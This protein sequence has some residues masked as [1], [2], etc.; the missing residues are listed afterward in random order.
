M[1][2]KQQVDI[3]IIIA[4]KGKEDKLCELRYCIFAAV[5][6]VVSKPCYPQGVTLLGSKKVN[7]PFV[8]TIIKISYR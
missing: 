4:V 7:L 8:Q 6:F 3:H 2:V 5:L 1:S